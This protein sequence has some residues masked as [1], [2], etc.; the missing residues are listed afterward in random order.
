MTVLERTTSLASCDHASRVTKSLLGYGVIA[1]P[2][3]VVV[4]LAQ[5]MTRQ[6]FDPTRHAWSLLSNGGLGW[7]QVTNFVAAGLMTVAFAVGLRRAGAGTGTWMPRLVAVYGVS[8]I[9]AGIFRADP[10]LGFPPGTPVNGNTV[11]WHGT[12][13]LASGSVGFL[14]LIAACLMAGRAFAA[15]GA[16][17]WAAY[18]RITGL[19]FLAG[20]AGIASGSHGAL[21]TLPFTAAVVLAWSWITALSIRI[22]RRTAGGVPSAI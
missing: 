20:F 5:A 14:C 11:S 6:G 1:G 2:V 18:S 21:T 19:V 16:R 15:R 7:I 9:A 17:G 13:H 10:A 8:L 3:Y 4:S 22:Y 12:L